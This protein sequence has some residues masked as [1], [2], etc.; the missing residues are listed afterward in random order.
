MRILSILICLH[1]PWIITTETLK[2]LTYSRL[3]LYNIFHEEGEIF[4]FDCHVLMF[5]GSL[6]PGAQQGPGRPRGA[7]QGP[8]GQPHLRPHGLLRGL[9]HC[10]GRSQCLPGE[11]LR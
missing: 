5:A 4:S 10:R 11:G 7:G 3:S 9:R 8:D 2:Q 1:L 6:C